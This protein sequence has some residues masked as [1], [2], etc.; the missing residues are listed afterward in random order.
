MLTATTLTHVTIISHLNLQNNLLNDHAHPPLL[1]RPEECF[2]KQA[3]LCPSFTSKFF[4]LWDLTYFKIIEEA[5]K[6][7]ASMWY[8]GK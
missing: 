8:D 4:E 1:L 3:C 2:K 5:W 6:V 7:D